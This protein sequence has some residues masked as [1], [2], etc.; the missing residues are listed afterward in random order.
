[1]LRKGSKINTQLKTNKAKF[2]VSNEDEYLII[3]LIVA[4]IILVMLIY[5]GIFSDSG[6]PHP[7]KSLSSEPVISTGL[8]R[9]FSEIVRLN[10][11]KALEFNPYSIHIFLFF[12]IQL[13]LRIFISFL[14]LSTSISKK[15]LLFTDILTSV[16]LF[17]LSFFHF[18]SAQL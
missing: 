9:A 6:I 14:L 12:F 3:N 1:M 16:L 18:I 5:S 8:S 7:I 15:L 10:F 13:L 11:Y 17:L 4:G 2:H